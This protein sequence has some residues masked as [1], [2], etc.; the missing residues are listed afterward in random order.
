MIEKK[1]VEYRNKIDLLE[2][3]NSDL[4]RDIVER[5]T[6]NKL[7]LDSRLELIHRIVELEDRVNKSEKEV[8]KLKNRKDQRF[9][10]FKWL[11]EKI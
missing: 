9:N 11:G 6:F 5:I 3:E 4:R 1:L 2:Q 10:L 7:M 8:E